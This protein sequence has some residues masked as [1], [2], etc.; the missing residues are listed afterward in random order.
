M[1]PNELPLEH[2]V[3]CDRSVAIKLIGVGGAGTNAVDRLKM[4]SLARLQLVAINTD[5]QAL[6]SSPV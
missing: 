5:N 3:L 4:E 6:S 2:Q 1:N